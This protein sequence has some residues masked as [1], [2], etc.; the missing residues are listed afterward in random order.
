VAGRD[1]SVVTQGARR[2]KKLTQALINLLGN[3]VKFTA[4]GEVVL[5][6][7]ARAEQRY[8]FEVIDTGPGIPLDRQEAIFEPFQ[9][10]QEGLQQGG[11][12]LGLAI[13]GKHIE[14]MGGQLEVDS[15]LD[16]GSR[17]FFTLELPPAQDEV[18]DALDNPWSRVIGLAPD[19]AVRALVVEN[20]AS[21]RDLLAQMLQQIGVEVHLATRGDQVVKQMCAS[22]PDI[23]FLDIRMPGMDGIETRQKIVDEFGA[24]A[25]K[26]VALSTA[27]IERQ[28]FLEVGFDGFIGKPFRPEHL[29]AS[30][31]ALLGTEYIYARAEPG[32][33]EKVLVLDPASMALPGPVLD[34]LKEAVKRQSVTELNKQLET[35]GALSDTGQVLAAH[36]R[37]LSQQYNMKAIGDI[38]EEIRPQ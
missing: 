27:V 24:E 16:Q 26:I 5:R 34:R 17:F 18:Q 37:Q 15:G 7:M 25:V 31:A 33:A 29:C 14:L 23:V 19:C 9:Q 3:A 28:N 13:S 30:M 21:N 6:V 36:L 20:T 8:N 11:T 22:M 1:G 10:D 38:L 35:L 2:R 32:V 12:G 4:E